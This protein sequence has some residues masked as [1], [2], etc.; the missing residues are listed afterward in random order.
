[1]V[2]GVYA[3]EKVITALKINGLV[4]KIVEGPHDYLYCEVRFSS[5]EK[6]AWLGQPHLIESMIES[7]KWQSHK[8]P[9]KLNFLIVRLM[10][11]TEE[12]SAEDKQKCKSRVGILLFLKKCSKPDTANVTKELLKAYDGANLQCFESCCE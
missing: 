12:I 1:M 6:R 10:I 11:D 7:K 2:G 4:L 8:T 3:I 9:G 5:G